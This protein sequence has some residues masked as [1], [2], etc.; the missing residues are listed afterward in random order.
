LAHFLG[1]IKHPFS[2]KRSGRQEPRLAPAG[3]WP[4][5]GWAGPTMP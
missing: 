1:G 2:E 3:G 5:A 4:S